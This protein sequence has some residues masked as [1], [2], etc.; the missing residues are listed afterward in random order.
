MDEE[1]KQAEGVDTEAKTEAKTEA[2]TLE[3]PVENPDPQV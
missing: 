2:V 3:T 1:N